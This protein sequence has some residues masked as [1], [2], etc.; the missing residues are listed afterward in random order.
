MDTESSCFF[1]ALIAGGASALGSTILVLCI[2][3]I[4][5]VAVYQCVYKPRLRRSRAV[6][7]GIQKN[8]DNCYN[9]STVPADHEHEYTVIY[10]AIGE[11]VNT[12]DMELKMNRNEVYGLA[13]STEI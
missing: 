10:E 2:S 12:T 7:D 4:I 13:A 8:D 5:H 9:K 3:V 11:G 6:F 1:S